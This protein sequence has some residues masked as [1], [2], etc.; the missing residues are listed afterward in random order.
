MQRLHEAIQSAKNER[1]NVAV[2]EEGKKAELVLPIMQSLCKDE[3]Y[4][5]VQDLHDQIDELSTQLEQFQDM[6]D[7][8]PIVK[9]IL[10]LEQLVV[11]EHGNAPEH[12]IAH[13]NRAFSPVSR[14]ENN[15]HAASM[16]GQ[17]ATAFGTESQDAK[18]DESV[19]MKEDRIEKLED[20]IIKLNG[21]V[22]SLQGTIMKLE[23]KIDN[24][25]WQ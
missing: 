15:K 20:L 3:K 21:K 22:E 23:E 24:Y 14:D 18:N 10:E 8:I 5:S 16:T 4:R 7:R 19:A 2:M 12:H 25:L 17:E 13:T 9:Q 1:R 11:K 6:D